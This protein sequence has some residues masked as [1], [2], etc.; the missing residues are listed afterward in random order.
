MNSKIAKLALVG[1]VLLLITIV[2]ITPAFAPDNNSMPNSNGP[3][4]DVPEWVRKL[5][6]EKPAL[7]LQYKGT[8][9]TLYS[10]PD[11]KIVESNWWFFIKGDWAVLYALF[12]ELNILEEV[13]GTYDYF[14]IVLITQDVVPIANG[15]TITG[16]SYWWKNG[17]FANEFETAI[18]IDETDL[19]G[20]FRMAFDSEWIDGSLTP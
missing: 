8:F 16:T 19:W 10:D 3:A 15:Y 6:R 2:G 20:Q 9:D 18:I 11:A 4:C 7:A 14:I 13:P 17:V 12:T 5:I 1:T